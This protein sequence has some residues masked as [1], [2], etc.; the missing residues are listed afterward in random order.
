MTLLLWSQWARITHPEIIKLRV[1]QWVQNPPIGFTISLIRQRR[2][3]ASS[4][5]LLTPHA[6]LSSRTKPCLAQS[7]ASLSQ[8]VMFYLPKMS[9]T[10]LL[11]R[12]LIRNSSCTIRQRFCL[13]DNH[14][15]IKIMRRLRAKFKIWRN[16]RQ[17]REDKIEENKCKM[18]TKLS[19]RFH[20]QALKL[21]GCWIRHWKLREET[22]WTRSANHIQCSTTIQIQ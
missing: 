21:I 17:R 3:P 7:I 22:H 13:S 9:P 5:C 18:I 19:L 2:D 10:L 15:W 4:G 1:I 20:R 14:L 12:M 6:R 11:S 8:L 16:S